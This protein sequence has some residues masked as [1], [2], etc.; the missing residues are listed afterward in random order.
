M[1][2]R[3]IT[4]EADGARQL[5]TTA[6]LRSFVSP[7]TLVVGL[8]AIVLAI[9]VMFSGTDVVPLSLWPIL[10][11]SI[12]AFVF[13]SPL[14]TLFMDH[15]ARSPMRRFSA[16]LSMVLG[17]LFQI[18]ATAIVIF[19]ALFIFLLITNAEVR[20]GMGFMIR[21]I[22]EGELPFSLSVLVQVAV[23]AGGIWFLWRTSKLEALLATPVERNLLMGDVS[24]TGI[25]ARL[26]YLFGVPSSMWHAGALLMPSLYLFIIA[27]LLVYS[28]Y[29]IATQGPA[30]LDLSSYDGKIVWVSLGIFVLVIALAHGAFILA[31]R[32][33]ARRIWASNSDDSARPILFLRS[34][35]DD[36]FSFRQ[37][38][39]DPISWWLNLWS[40]RRNADEMMIDEFAHYGPVIALGQ[41]GEESTP[42]G[43]QRQYASH[44]NWQ[45][46]I[47]AA[48]N[49][50]G[51][52]V[53]AAGSTPG[54]AWE[55]DLLKSED[56]LA[57]TVFL[58]PPQH[59]NP[60]DFKTAQ[61]IY[62]R[63]FGP[64]PQ[65]DR[66][67]TLL[68]VWLN[69]DTPKAWT[70]EAPHAQTYLVLLREFMQTRFKARKIE[71][72][73]IVPLILA[74]LGGAI[75]LITVYFFVMMAMDY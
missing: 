34:F 42:F 72:M 69:G 71:A 65:Y 9:V 49:S 30:L 63:S 28:V 47:K 35:E 25:W 64:L 38:L 20:E 13:F 8:V 40:F 26:A 55:Y 16:F 17:G 54:L 57:K 4:A 12:V 5:D 7:L 59:K 45:E 15:M 62:E 46:T 58:F 37:S 43:A 1:I 23:T 44:D 67:Q 50:A 22:F 33:A 61:E 29:W 51:A 52:I 14:I 39:R 36:Q 60:E 18:I 11:L 10:I 32:L 19:I 70:A 2:V 3:D 21:D 66:S 41:P 27:R 73:K 74:I 68:G 53:V 31:K 48:A 56:Y 75:A 6:A 24:D